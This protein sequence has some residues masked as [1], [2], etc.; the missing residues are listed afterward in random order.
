MLKRLKNKL[1][2]A[3]NSKFTTTNNVKEEPQKA[4]LSSSALDLTREEI[5]VI[6]IT[7]KDSTFRG[8][9]VEKVY[10]LVLK[11]QQ[12]YVSIKP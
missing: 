3:F 4:P 9:H 2:M 12:Y 8:E 5:E 6:L 7:I 11:L 1:V 10:N